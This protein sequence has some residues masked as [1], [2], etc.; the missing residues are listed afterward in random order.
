MTISVPSAYK[1]APADN[2]RT[3]Y[4]ARSHDGEADILTK[5]TNKQVKLSSNK[6]S[7]Y[8]LA[9]RDTYNGGRYIVPTTG[10]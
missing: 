9:Y 6:F 8:A 2:F 4:L 5:T 3:F 1:N 7:I 10:D